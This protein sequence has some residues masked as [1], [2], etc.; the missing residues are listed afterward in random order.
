MV[1]RDPQKDV[2]RIQTDLCYSLSEEKVTQLKILEV[3]TTFSKCEPKEVHSGTIPTYFF[4]GMC[5]NLHQEN[6]NSL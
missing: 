5:L 4:D 6:K 3:V 1:S 2:T